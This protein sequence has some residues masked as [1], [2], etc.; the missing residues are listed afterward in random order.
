MTMSRRSFLLG[1]AAATAG[2]ARF[3][4]HTGQQAAASDG[5]VR[6]ATV[7]SP[8]K[9]A[10]LTDEIGQD[11]ARVAEVAAAELGLGWV[12]LREVWGKNL[13]RLDAAEVAEAKR[14]LARFGL[15]VTAIASPLF[16]VDWPGAPRSRFSPVGGQFKADWTFEQQDEV[17]DRC[18]RLAREFGT[19]RIRCFDFWR[20]D[21]VKPYRAAIDDTLRKAAAKAAAAKVLLVL[22]NEP[23]CNT[24]TAAEATATLAAVRSDAFKLNWDAGNSQASGETAYPEGYGLLPK[25]RVGHVHVKDAIYKGDGKFAWAAMG[26]GAIDWTGQFRALLR[27]GYRG[28]VVL[29]THWR[30]A[31][32]GEASTRRCWTAMSR[33]LREAGAL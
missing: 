5:V 7:A 26:E 20:L 31:G 1:A 25:D 23:A 4:A 22:E 33:Q 17:F 29:E 32:T 14:I 28:P 24:A 12:E 30:G 9:I 27:D 13:T 6:K 19:D 16:K 10:V 18:V 3:S 2:G 21:D 15:G 11:L 8:F